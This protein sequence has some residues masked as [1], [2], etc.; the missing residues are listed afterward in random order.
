MLVQY[1]PKESVASVAKHLKQHST[2]KMW[3]CHGEYFCKE[4]WKHKVLWSDGY[5]AASIGEA[6]QATIERYIQNQG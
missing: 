6:S 4:Y 2:H 3:Q 5:F 1:K